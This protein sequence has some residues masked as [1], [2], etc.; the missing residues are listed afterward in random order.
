[1]EKLQIIHDFA[2][3]MSVFELRGE[4]KTGVRSGELW[5]LVGKA[6]KIDWDLKRA[7]HTIAYQALIGKADFNSAIGE[8][9]KLAEK[10]EKEAT[11]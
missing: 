3:W 1:M 9:N 11:K 10:Y 8:L 4:L 6:Q 2:A 5:A 7:L